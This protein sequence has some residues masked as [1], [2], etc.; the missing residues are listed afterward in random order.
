MS[1]ERVKPVRQQLSVRIRPHRSLEEHL[2]LL[3]PAALT[4]VTGLIWRLPPKSRL[5]RAAT[6]RAVKLGLEAANRRDHEA[7][8]A[9][10]HPNIEYIT[11]PQLVALGFDSVYRGREGRREVQERWLTD[12]GEFQFKPEELIDM[13]DGHLLMIGRMEGSGLSSQVGIDN[14]WANL[15]TISAGRVIRE[16]VFLDRTEALEAAGLSE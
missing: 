4:W 2:G 9:L 15:V 10:Y 3:F 1:Q 7:G 5:R 8:F 6:R 14:D 16:Q 11:P 12:W 13:G